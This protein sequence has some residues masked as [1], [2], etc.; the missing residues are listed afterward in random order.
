MEQFYNLLLSETYG[1]VMLIYL[2]LFTIP[3][4]LATRAQSRAYY[5]IQRINKLTFIACF[6]IMC[7]G[8]AF[9]NNGTDTEW[10]MNFFEMHRKFA[11]CEYGPVEIGFQ[12]YNVLVH[13]VTDNPVIYIILT[14]GVMM[15]CVCVAFYLIR[16]KSLIWLS[17]LGFAAIVYFMMFSALR[18][19]MAYSM[20]FL[21]YAYGVKKKYIRSLLVA[22]LGS[23]IH[24]SMILLV[25]P[26]LL[27]LLFI[28][29][30]PKI[31]VKL[32]VP[33]LLISIIIV[34]LYGK[35]II[36]T[37]FMTD[38]ILSGKYSGYL[39]DSSEQGFMIFF[40][41]FP[42][43]YITFDYKYL[44][45]KDRNLFYLNLFLAIVGFS[46]A[47]LA[48]QIG[49]LTRIVPFYSFPFIFYIGYYLQS[50]LRDRHLSIRKI[51][52]YTTFMVVYWFY[53]FSTVISG[54]F[55]NNGLDSYELFRI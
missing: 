50:A 6:T 20:G 33:L 19:S 4:I 43:A 21:V 24:R 51:K 53:R 26:L 12:Y 10:Y 5:D 8:L 54:L 27:Y 13:Y 9:A 16:D 23:F 55:F 36:Q 39:Q 47:L 3:C 18:N 14:R 46:F 48:Y 29:L 15:L 38:D 41:Y 40:V 37:I 30:A 32:I 25:G 22:L 45:N 49:Q 1:R 11:D 42:I 44:K 28:K 7:G 2:G 31:F 17:L 52:F 35:I 34:Y